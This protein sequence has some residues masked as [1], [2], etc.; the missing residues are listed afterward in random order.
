MQVLW[1]LIWLVAFGFTHYAFVCRGPLK[2]PGSPRAGSGPRSRLPGRLT[3]LYFA[4][5]DRGQVVLG[6]WIMAVNLVATALGENWYALLL[7]I[8]G[9]GALLDPAIHAP[10]RLQIMTTLS[11]LEP[12]DRVAFPRLQDHLS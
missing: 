5:R 10:V 3:G 1:G 4:R 12:G 8:L 11:A 9:G 6:A 2:L 7:A